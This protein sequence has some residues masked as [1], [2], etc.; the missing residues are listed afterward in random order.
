MK[1]KKTRERRRE[2]LA[3]YRH[4]DRAASAWRAAKGR[5]R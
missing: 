1:R 2:V 5:G 4:S 3:A